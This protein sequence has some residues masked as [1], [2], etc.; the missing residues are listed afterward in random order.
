MNASLKKHSPPIIIF[1]ILS[2]TCLGIYFHGLSG[3]FVFDDAENIEHNSLLQI[4]SLDL[5]SV[6]SSA[7]SGR[8]GPLKRPIAMLSFALNYYF[9][10][11]LNP[12]AFKIT[13]VFIQILCGWLVFVLSR[14]LLFK[15]NT[16]NSNPINNTVITYFAFAVALLWV[17]H[18][19]N[20]TSVL[21][22]V[23]R[24]T[25]L[26]TLFTLA[27]LI[28][29]I[30]ARS[31][32]PLSFFSQGS[33]FYF[34]SFVSFLLA[35]FSKENALLM[36]TYLLLIEWIF[37]H[38]RQP[39]AYITSLPQQIRKALWLTLSII[40]IASFLFA[41]DY[42][43]NGYSS[44]TFSLTE[45]VL[46]ETRIICYYLSLIVFPRINAFGIFHDDIPLSTSLIDPWT[47]LLAIIFIISLITVAIRLRKNNPLVAFGLL[48]FFSGHLLESTIFGLEIAHEH[49]NHLPS[50]G[51]ILAI[52]GIFFHQQ[53]IKKKV[54]ILFTNAFF[55][56]FSITTMLRA[57]QWKDEYSLAVYEAK[58]HPESPATLGLLSNAAFNNK[59]YQLSE[60][61][62]LRAKD[63]APEESAYAI[64]SLVI[65]TL[66]GK[67]VDKNLANDVNTKLKKNIL[68]ASTQIALAHIS[69]MLNNKNLIPLRPY[70]IEWLNI[71]LGKLGDNRKASVYHYFLAKTYLANGN[72]LKAINSHQQAFILD[73][74][75]I[76]PLFEIGNIFLSLKQADNARIVLAQIEKAHEN[77]NLFR[78]Y[79]THIEELKLAIQKIENE[80]TR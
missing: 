66:L 46:T 68:S 2:I 80:S 17:A 62:I 71:T 5:D 69:T 77:P 45:R 57:D 18:P 1:F 60:T 10:D 23:Q 26:S 72:T 48:F 39:W 3:P 67:P 51:I 34:V 44:R 35:I 43:S 28:F 29:Y 49:R 15:A 16:I 47:T 33:F 63:L 52:I 65:T 24:M 50:I 8:A 42:A 11:G 30:K 73:K 4:T 70:Y 41:L 19:I 32:M 79:D 36:P 61:A 74:K 14:L 21:Y 53:R 31:N 54:C 6:S 55:I 64:N 76:N 78:R 22:I 56:I 25:S 40:C 58:H 20:L 13:N 7:L 27:T 75:F 9:A 38:Q 12:F 37:F 59:E